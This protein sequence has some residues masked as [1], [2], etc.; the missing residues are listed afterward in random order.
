MRY[1]FAD[2][3]VDVD[4]FELRRGGEPVHVERQV[5]DVLAY[6]LAHRNRV[7]PKHELLDEVWG[8]RFVSESALTSRIK[9]ARRA[10]GDDGATQRVIR[11]SFGRGYQFVADDVKVLDEEIHEPTETSRLQGRPPPEQEIRFCHADDGIRIAYALVGDGP[12]L[13]KAAN[14]MTHLDFERR[15]PVWRHW[16][17]GL[18]GHRTLLRYD[19]RGC[20]LSDWDVDRFDFD[21]WVDD[22]AAVVDDA[23]WERFPLLGVSQGAAVAVAFAVRFPERVSRLVLYG[24]YA[25]GRMAR[26]D[27]E[28]LRR[29]AALDIELARVGWGSDDPSFRQVFTSQFLPGGSREDWDEF[30]ELQRRT[31]SAD[32][33]VRFL[34]TFATI[35]VTAEA[36]RVRCPTIVMHVRDDHRVPWAAA[37]EMAALIP[38]SRLV[39]LPG[40]NHLLTAIE[41]AW[42]M[43]LAELD[44]FLAE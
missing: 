25:R 9:A 10:V 38:G 42:P 31:T 24:S 23:G 44:R 18:S 39:T 27:S 22:L 32:N 43:F 8:D 26:A 20:G 6:L 21:V 4:R 17:D 15:N 2:L 13:V 14:W 3:E 29:G 37:R 7:V 33:A 19:E 40:E 34:D 12:P 36:R 5:F 28:A 1:H 41:P 11:T 30:N 35:D 16:I